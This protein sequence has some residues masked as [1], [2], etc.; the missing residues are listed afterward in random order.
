MSVYRDSNGE[1]IQLT[2]PHFAAGGEGQVYF[3]KD[4]LK[5]QNCC[6]KIY[7]KNKINTNRQDKLQYMVLNPPPNLMS[8]GY[9]ICWPL[10]ILFNEKGFCGFIMPLAF[11]NSESPYELCNPKINAKLS[12]YW[13][14]KYRRDTD[15]GRLSRLKLCV[16]IAIAVHAIHTTARYIL[17]DLKPQNLLVTDH[18]N[19]SII[20][21]DSIQISEN[22]RVL[23]YGSAATADY[24]PPEAKGVN[25]QKQYISNHWDE[26]SLAVI[27]YQLLTGVHPYASTT[28]PEYGELP[29]IGEKISFGLFVHGSKSASHIKVTPP[30]HN[31]F[32]LHLA[33]EIRKLF[34][35]AFDYGHTNPNVRPSAEE[36]GKT[37]FR[38]VNNTE[39]LQPKTNS[40]ARVVPAPQVPPVR[41]AVPI[42]PPKPRVTQRTSKKRTAAVK[43]TTPAY[44]RK[45]NQPKQPSNIGGVLVFVL[46][47]LLAIGGY[48]FL[49]GKGKERMY[50]K[51]VI[52]PEEKV[53]TKIYKKSKQEKVVEDFITYI[54]NQQLDEAYELSRNENWKSKS[55]FVKGYG[56]VVSTNVKEIKLRN[57][58]KNYPI[59]WI[60]YYAKDPVNDRKKHGRENILYYQDF[61]LR[62][63][64]G[65]FKITKAT[66][67]TPELKV[68][69]DFLDYLAEGDLEEAYDLIDPFWMQ[70]KLFRDGYKDITNLEIYDFKIIKNKNPKKSVIWVKYFAKDPVNDSS[71][72]GEMYHQKF[73]IKEISNKLRITRIEKG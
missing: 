33:P 13:H 12:S 25:F 26:F 70:K 7:F 11:K 19:V 21:F 18:G 41:Q 27:F 43:A 47:I 36:W 9:R 17:L 15:L 54:G 24:M 34:L 53:D 4:S 1:I 57:S 38:I 67:E 28:K 68:A 6:A 63:F 37:L 22:K 71:R 64:K 73:H 51:E 39:V 60:K 45:T 23:F 29:S 14:Q 10:S 56:G 16:N 69:L 46:L 52:V 62:D 20:D 58:P 61:H 50:S 35:K 32:H 59:V 31:T 42:R 3:I 49:F 8:S 5:Y 40:R 30:F 66:L 48:Y 55:S 44:K 2:Q 72:A 65:E